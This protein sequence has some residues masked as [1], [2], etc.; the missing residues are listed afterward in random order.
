MRARDFT[1]P[2]YRFLLTEAGSLARLAAPAIAV[3]LAGNLVLG[4]AGADYE[5][6]MFVANLVATIV[7][8]QFA[9]VVLG[10][11]LAGRPPVVA[12]L[13]RF[14][15][16][17][18]SLFWRSLVAAI[19]AGLP[20][21]VLGAVFLVTALGR[22][23]GGSRGGPN[24]EV[25]ALI[26][27]PPGIIATLWLGCRLLLVPV[28]AVLPPDMPVFSTAWSLTRGRFWLML[29]V[30]LS[31]VLPL[32]AL[33]TAAFSSF[34]FGITFGLSAAVLYGITLG[35]IHLA[36]VAVGSRALVALYRALTAAAAA[37][38][39]SEPAAPPASP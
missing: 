15:G 4:L 3:L 26:L 20:A 18:W 30:L 22:A 12:D 32:V 6:V 2:A 17:T 8:T 9:R 1:G 7:F 39:R 14:D 13:P 21:L 23:F 37:A 35:V 34:E 31:L 10:G 5:T 16:R 11:L 38:P 28:L 24:E 27:L 25:L 29:R 33:H 36:F 19:L